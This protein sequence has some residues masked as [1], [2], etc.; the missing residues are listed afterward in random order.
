METFGLL[1]ILTSLLQ[2]KTAEPFSPPTGETKEENPQEKIP[3]SEPVE[4]RE[5]AFLK[6]IERH[7]ERSK[8]IDG[9]KG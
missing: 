3:L 7:N 1:K 4:E 6:L 8:R 2:S 9:K 5:N